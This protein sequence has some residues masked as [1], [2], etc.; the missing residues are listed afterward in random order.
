MDIRYSVVSFG[1]RVGL[2]CQDYRQFLA[3]N[4][5]HKVRPSSFVPVQVDLHHRQPSFASA[6]HTTNVGFCIITTVVGGLAVSVTSHVSRLAVCDQCSD[7]AYSPL[8]R[9]IY[10]H[11]LY[12]L[13]FREESAESFVPICV[14]AR[15]VDLLLLY[16]VRILAKTRTKART[17][18]MCARFERHLS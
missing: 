17:Q 18:N 5:C 11:S 16:F 8:D 15:A 14:T 9:V 6:P 10:S 1:Y 4:L 12:C 2:L 13:A 3:Y 7:T